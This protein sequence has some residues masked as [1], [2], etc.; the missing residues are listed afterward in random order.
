MILNTG[1]ISYGFVRP[2]NYTLTFQEAKERVEAMR[3][4][5]IA[6]LK[7]Q[8]LRIENLHIDCGSVEQ[9]V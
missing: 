8:I 1:K 6:S 5:K 7:K 2:N 3:L 4:K 9:E